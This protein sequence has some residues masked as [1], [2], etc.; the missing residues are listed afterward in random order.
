MGSSDKHRDAVWDDATMAAGLRKYRTLARRTGLVES[1][2]AQWHYSGGCLDPGGM[3]RIRVN[4]FPRRATLKA[5]VFD[6]WQDA[7]SEVKRRVLIGAD[8]QSVVEWM[9]DAGFW[10][11]PSRH[12]PSSGGFHAETWMIEG[13]R[14]GRFHFVRRNTWSI[15]DGEGAEVFGVGKSM[16]RLAGLTRFE[17]PVK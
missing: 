11:L 9:K 5:E 10:R 13:F 15:L 14:D 17:D 7:P 1:Y 6:A 3:I 12:H 16:A 2:L 8:W 4:R